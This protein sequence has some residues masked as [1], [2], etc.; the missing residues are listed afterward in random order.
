MSV[1]TD[2]R[3]VLCS[4]DLLYH[5]LRTQFSWR[6][7]H[8]FIPH[9]TISPFRAAQRAVAGACNSRARQRGRLLTGRATG[10]ELWEHRQG[11]RYLVR[12]CKFLDGEVITTRPKPRWVFFPLINQILVLILY[13]RVRSTTIGPI[14]CGLLVLGL[15]ISG[16][17]LLFFCKVYSMCVL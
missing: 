17:Y 11:K 7:E 5:S 8:D 12:A 2:L 15:S 3:G 1:R 9:L 4:L 10:L 6:R 13:F 16:C 14:I